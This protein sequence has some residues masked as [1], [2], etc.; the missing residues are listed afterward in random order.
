MTGTVRL[1]RLAEQRKELAV[2]YR[3]LG[4][5]RRAVCTLGRPASLEKASPVD[6]NLIGE[7]ED[8]VLM[9]ESDARPAFTVTPVHDKSAAVH[10]NPV[11]K[12]LLKF[13]ALGEFIVAPGIQSARILVFQNALK[14]LRA[15]NPQF[16]RFNDDVKT[17]DL[18]LHEVDALNRLVERIR[19]VVL[20]PDYKARMLRSQRIA[21][22]RHKEACAYL[23]DIQRRSG[24]LLVIPLEIKPGPGWREEAG[25]RE[26]GKKLPAVVERFNAFKK[27]ARHRSEWAHVV[28]FVGRWERS[29]SQGLYARVLFLLES[30]RVSDPREAAEAIG[31]YWATFTEDKGSFDPAYFI[32]TDAE[33]LIPFRQVCRGSAR[34]RREL[35][36]VALPYFTRQELVFRDPDLGLEERFFRGE[37]PS[38]GARPTPESAPVSKIKVTAVSTGEAT[39]GVEAVALETAKPATGPEALPDAC[40]SHHSDKS[41]NPQQS[42]KK[43]PARRVVHVEIR[44]TRSAFKLRP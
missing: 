35:L 17:T 31:R 30:A 29:E 43:P 22:R 6:F 5:Q 40:S 36:E 3:E 2:L 15:E 38:S 23:E 18:K 27:K 11:G 26:A 12:V 44:P 16:R 14:E 33:M 4:F 34:H 39:A 20:S 28:G 8:L 10:A 42:V 25:R 41:T 1:Q 7:V 24:D 32:S 9:I 37:C 21:D 13:S 19:Q